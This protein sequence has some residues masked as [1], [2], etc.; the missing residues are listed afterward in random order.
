MK[1]TNI[2]LLFLE[3]VII[4]NL[5]ETCLS[6]SWNQMERDF[7]GRWKIEKEKDWKNKK[8]KDCGNKKR[9]I[10]KIQW[11]FWIKNQSPG[12]WFPTKDWAIGDNQ[13][14]KDWPTWDEEPTK[15]RPHAVAVEKEPKID[16]FAFKFR[17]FLCRTLNLDLHAV[18]LLL[19]QGS[20]LLVLYSHEF[21]SDFVQKYGCSLSLAGTSINY[22]WILRVNQL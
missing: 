4:A 22:E 6:M 7:I 1:E 5:A 3:H 21:V 14:T 17:V 19:D 9:K 12:K 11:T 20:I 15:V 16:C 2:V 10:A 13:Q 8:E 18:N